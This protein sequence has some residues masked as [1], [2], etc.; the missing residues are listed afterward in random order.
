MSPDESVGLGADR[1]SQRLEDAIVEATWLYS[2]DGL[3]QNEIAQRLGLSR[4][5]VV[6][7][8][9]EGRRRNY[10]RVT[11]DTDIFAGHRLAA[12]LRETLGLKDALVVPADSI[13]PQRSAD[14]VTRA[15]S[16]WLPQLLAPGDRLGVA[17]GETV[18]R[19]AEAAPRVSIDG[20]T[21]VQMVGLR[22]SALGFA[23]EV[24]AA[25]LAQRLGGR[26]INLHAPLLLTERSLAQRLCAEPVIAEQLHAVATCNKTVFACGTV[27]PQSHIAMTGLLDADQLA[28]HR[29]AGATGVICARLIDGSGQPVHAEIENRMIGVTLQQMQGK[30]MAL[31]VAPGR[32]RAAPALAAIRGGYATHLVTCSDTALELL[33]L[34]T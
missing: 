19:L 2:H 26:L 9:A 1:R 27:G 8:L 13:D 16:D 21:V 28:Q 29:A 30:E 17:W 15:A 33:E 12:L 22:A 18:F 6:N 5:T 10:V 24:C 23:A 3:N 20:L 25:T 32:D 7:Y 11:L 31:L 34:M 4:A 14:R